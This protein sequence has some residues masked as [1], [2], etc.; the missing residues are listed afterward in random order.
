MKRKR[1]R[2]SFVAS[3]EARAYFD[4]LVVRLT[5]ASALG[6]RVTYREAFDRMV[7]YARAGEAQRHSRSVM[8][9][10]SPVAAKT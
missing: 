6:T 2:I 9:R 8:A 1:A 7:D 4:T 5:R 3:V 10:V